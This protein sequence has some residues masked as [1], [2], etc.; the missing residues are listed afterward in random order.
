MYSQKHIIFVAAVLSLLLPIACNPVG[1]A[2]TPLRKQ[3][4]PEW[5]RGEWYE[6][7]SSKLPVGDVVATFT[8]TQYIYKG[9][10]FDLNN[11]G[12]MSFGQ[13]NVYNVRILY[14][15]SPDRMI[16]TPWGDDISLVLTEYKGIGRSKTRGGRT[17]AKKQS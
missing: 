1:E 8:E 16:Y 15:D 6:T 7:D 3:T 10:T 17:L 12:N 11:P 13:L 4:F 2:T 5:I 9:K 14:K